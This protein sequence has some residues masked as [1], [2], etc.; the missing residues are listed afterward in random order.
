MAECLAPNFQLIFTSFRPLTHPLTHSGLLFWAIHFYS[1][2][3]CVHS[4]TEEHGHE[5]SVCPTLQSPL[6]CLVVHAVWD[7]ASLGVLSICSIRKPGLIWEGVSA[8]VSGGKCL[9]HWKI[10]FYEWIFL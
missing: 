3:H 6:L 7:I 2:F 10:G 8:G 4:L 1:G 9:L 5:H